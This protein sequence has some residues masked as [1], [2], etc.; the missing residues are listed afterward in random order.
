MEIFLMKLVKRWTSTN[1]IVGNPAIDW[2]LNEISS[3]TLSIQHISSLMIVMGW[4]L[5][6][7]N[8]PK[9]ALT[10]KRLLC[11]SIP[12]LGATQGFTRGIAQLLV[13]ELSSLIDLQTNEDDL[14]LKNLFFFLTHNKDMVSSLLQKLNCAL[15]FGHYS[16]KPCSKNSGLSNRGSFQ[17]TRLSTLCRLYSLC[18]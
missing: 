18:Q 4:L 16:D 2:L 13:H 8:F 7:N 6:S 1:E 10:L 9:D 12:W 14:L 15:F 17:T 3:P 11:Y 5:T